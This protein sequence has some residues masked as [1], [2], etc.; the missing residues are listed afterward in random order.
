MPSFFSSNISSYVLSIASLCDIRGANSGSRGGAAWPRLAASTEA[1]AYILRS[2]L[3][4]GAVCPC[5]T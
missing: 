5:L 1:A 4:S 2:M 3:V